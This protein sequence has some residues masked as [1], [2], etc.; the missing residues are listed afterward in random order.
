MHPA[1]AP[2]CTE[3]GNVEYY[4]C[5]SCEKNFA[6]EE[7]KNGLTTVLDPAKGH[8]E[9]VDNAVAPSCSAS[10]LTEG[11]HCDVCKEVIVKQETVDKESH[12]FNEGKC[13]VCGETDPDYKPSVTPE[14]GDTTPA[15]AL[16]S[17]MLMSVTALVAL[18]LFHKKRRA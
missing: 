4:T 12:S 11:K 1:K 17:V 3:D 2:T 5:V 16:T 18:L 10:G 15:I 13:S 14:T 9:V 7:G 8:A 6:D